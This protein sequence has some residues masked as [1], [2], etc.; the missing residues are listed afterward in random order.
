[1]F[2]SVDVVLVGA[3]RDFETHLL[4]VFATRTRLRREGVAL[5]EL[6]PYF[7]LETCVIRDTQ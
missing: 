6:F 2:D 7:V 4:Q 1:M 3:L 5:T